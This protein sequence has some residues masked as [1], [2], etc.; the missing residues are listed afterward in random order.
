[1]LK[2]VHH[3]KKIFLGIVVSINV[4]IIL[5]SFRSKLIPSDSNLIF[6]QKLS[7]LC[8]IGYAPSRFNPRKQ[9]YPSIESIKADLHILKKAG[10]NGVITFG[11]EKSLDQIPE[12]AKEIGF[13]GV[14]M[15]IWAPDSHEEVE[16]AIAAKNYVDGYCVGHMGLNK[17][18][19]LEILKT[20][21]AKIKKRTQLPV[22]TTEGID[23]YYNESP[24]IQLSDWIFPDSRIYWQNENIDHLKQL[25]KTLLK[26][27][28]RLIGLSEKPVLLKIVGFPTMGSG[29]ASEK[30]QA[31]LF[32]LLLQNAGHPYE[33][34][35]FAY[36]EAFDQ[37][38]K[39]WHTVEAHWGVFKNDRSPKAGADYI[40]GKNITYSDEHGLKQNVEPLLW[41]TFLF[42]S[43]VN[44]VMG[45]LYYMIC[46]RTRQEKKVIRLAIKE[47][48]I[49]KSCH[50]QLIEIK[51][52]KTHQKCF[53]ILLYFISHRD[54]PLMCGEIIKH[55]ND[56]VFTCCSYT[57][58]DGCREK[59]DQCQPYR[60]LC[61][62]RIRVIKKFCQ[63]HNIGNITNIAG[64]SKWR[65]TLAENVE[66]EIVG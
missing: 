38:W 62:H 56:K 60:T 40:W 1:M 59:K 23:V 24:L 3:R 49:Y 57:E 51:I 21:M 58:Q 10:F 17:N 61:N 15:G 42:V 13:E 32:K 53:G 52:E 41:I 33:R 44:A 2:L 25:Y 46:I 14:I 65:L 48:K 55:I 28:E 35:R 36:F 63:D 20:A 34:L 16:S 7:S 4:I 29:K 6:I 66:I 19:N 30:N 31:E 43:C 5:S 22:T 47:K 50:K 12:V 54:R 18:Y 27:Y 9:I 39:T 11:A 37:P 8:W 64:E 26:D 45:C